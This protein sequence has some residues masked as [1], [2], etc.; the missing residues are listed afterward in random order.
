MEPR[1]AYRDLGGEGYLAGKGDKDGACGGKAYAN[2]KGA[3]S[4]HQGDMMD[5]FGTAA[6]ADLNPNDPGYRVALRDLQ[7][8]D[9]LRL[10]QSP[11]LDHISATL[12]GTNPQYQ[13][14]SEGARGIAAS[15]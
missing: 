14:T 3:A 15:M 4:Q 5:P 1:R 13:V 12:M 6:G 10:W 2:V 9:V 7:N 11:N 8:A